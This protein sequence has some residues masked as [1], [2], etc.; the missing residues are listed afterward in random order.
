MCVVF[1][2][3]IRVPKVAQSQRYKGSNDVLIL[4]EEVHVGI[5]L[6]PQFLI[7]FISPNR[8]SQT[9][10]KVQIIPMWTGYSRVGSLFSP[11]F[12]P[13]SSKVVAKT[14]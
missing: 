11:T 14:V 6:K 8:G 10:S 5:D 7:I 4:F 12:G 9:P 2:R 1:S 13:L 3:E